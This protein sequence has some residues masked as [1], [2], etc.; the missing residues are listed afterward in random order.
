MT[1]SM[2][3]TDVVSTEELKTEFKYVLKTS[4]E[5]SKKGEILSAQ[6]IS[7]TAPT[8]RTTAECAA[9]KQAFFRAMGEQ[10]GGDPDKMD[11]DFDI[12]GSDIMTL[13]AM[14][15]SVDLPDVLAIGKKLFQQPGI[16]LIDGEIKFGNELMNRMSVDDLE[17]LLGEYL[18]NFILASSLKRLRE[19]SVKASQT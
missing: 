19:K 3:D 5:Y 13:I 7:L 1:E 15:K 18:V 11:Q 6:F 10:E 2:H 12:E 9:L 4:F 17:D 8:S 14:A 16:A